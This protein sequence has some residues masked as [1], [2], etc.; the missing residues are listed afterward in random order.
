MNWKITKE[1]QRK[2]ADNSYYLRAERECFELR[3]KLNAW[4]RLNCDRIADT[5]SSSRELIFTPTTCGLCCSKVTLSMLLLVISL[6]QHAEEAITPDLVR[7]LFEDSFG[8]PDHDDLVRYQR[9]AV[10]KIALLSEGGANMVLNEL[11]LRLKASQDTN[12][13]QILGSILSKDGVKGAGRFVELAEAVL[14]GQL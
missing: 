10:V 12:S 9:W 4:T 2:C 3:T 6:I 1:I 8:G 5:G 14:S 13:A 7:L 11:R